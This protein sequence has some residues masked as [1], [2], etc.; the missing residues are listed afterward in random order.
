MVDSTRVIIPAVSTIV[1]VKR[2]GV[3]G[4]AR[5]VVGGRVAGVPTTRHVALVEATVQRYR[6][7]L[8]RGTVVGRAAS[9]LAARFHT[10]MCRAVFTSSGAYVRAFSRILLYAYVFS[11]NFILNPIAL[12]WQSGK[13]NIL[14]QGPVH[15]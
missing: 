7:A 13:P 12:A 14:R 6:S 4:L 8:A 15:V 9:V 1:S 3:A 10:S 2:G 11:Y 5:A